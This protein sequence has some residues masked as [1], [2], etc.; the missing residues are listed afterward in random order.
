M[1][2]RSIDAQLNQI[3]LS[4]RSRGVIILFFIFL[5]CFHTYGQS[6]A[7]IPVD[8]LINKTPVDEIA[9]YR[10]YS[11]EPLFSTD[12]DLRIGAGRSEHLV[13]SGKELY[14]LVEG[15]GRVYRIDSTGE[16]T[17]IDSTYFTGYNFGAYTFNYRDTIYSL[18][19]YGF[20]HQNGHLRF[21]RF[22]KHSWEIELLNRELP[23]LLGTGS[24]TPFTSWSLWFDKKHGNLIYPTRP[25]SRSWGIDVLTDT[26][27]VWKLDLIE[28]KWS[29][30]GTLN[31][32]T[33]SSIETSRRIFSLP[34][35]ELFLNAKINGILLDYH[36]NEVRE[37]DQKISQAINSF[38]YQANADNSR[39][40]IY[41]RDSTLTFHVSEQRKLVLHLTERDF[42][43]TGK[44]IF[45]PYKK[46]FF[47]G[48]IPGIHLGLFAGASPLRLGYFTRL[49]GFGLSPKECLNLCMI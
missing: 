8:L 18:G 47:M 48:G 44:T 35:G 22:D 36:S 11:Q 41:R 5:A 3:N 24:P 19:G 14:Y 43:A 7:P 39:V 15:T 16:F 6:N 12:L 17:R 33:S 2:C 21:F 13:A 25:F 10:R 23:V 38:I 46:P 1:I 28:K 49:I 9:I 27:R 45:V 37:L 4:R 40:F 29:I 34:W 30:L 26:S 32:E 31:K 42:K 20:W